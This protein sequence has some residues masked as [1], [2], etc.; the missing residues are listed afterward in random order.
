MIQQEKKKVICRSN[1]EY[2]L[3]LEC[4]SW[5]RNNFERFK[6][7]CIIP[8]PNELAYKRKDVVIKDGCSDLI[9]AM[10]GKTIYVELKIGYNNQQENQKEFE[11]LINHL[12]QE[13][14]II[15]SLEQFKKYINEI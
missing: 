6:S 5:F 11:I 8:V 14:K 15:R 9:I 12:G 1:E 4:I 2:T 10:H 3:Q 7:G 13:Y